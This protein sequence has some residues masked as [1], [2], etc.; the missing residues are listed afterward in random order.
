M[1]KHRLFICIALILGMSLS[2]CVSKKKYGE[3]EALKN[4]VQRMLDKR[5]DDMD[6]LRAQLK[7]KQQELDDCQDARKALAQDTS[8]LMAVQDALNGE[9]DDVK[10][11]CAQ[12][13]DR[14]KQLRTKSTEKLRKLV[15]QLENLQEDLR[16]R[17]DRID[18]IESMLQQREARLA[19]VEGMLNQRDSIMNSLQQRLSDALLGFRDEGL[20]VDVKNG[21]VYVS[22]SN[23]LLFASGSTTID[24]KGQQ[25]LAD[26]ATVLKDQEDLTIMVEGHT[27]DVPVSNLGRIKDNWDLSVM[28][29]TEVVRLLVDN[30]VPPTRIVPAGH[31]EF[32]PKVDEK[33][34]EARAANRRTEI[35]ISPKLDE[36]FELIEA[37][38]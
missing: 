16:L 30:G 11:S 5:A 35:V 22:L 3:M 12:L 9:L 26:L 28:R 18:E 17:Q 24:A 27:D 29:S 36:L 33:T 20:T 13:D 4:K 31:G 1:M 21:K 15:D 8:R 25:A 14:Y 23:K 38:R 7:D 37:Q 34:T 2:A 19:E 32:I 6:D 10:S